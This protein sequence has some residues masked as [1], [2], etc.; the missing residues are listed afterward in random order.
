MDENF[1]TL[2]I[3]VEKAFLTLSR[4]FGLLLLD[5]HGGSSTS[6][7]PIPILRIKSVPLREIIDCLTEVLFIKVVQ[8][9]IAILALLFLGG[10]TDVLVAH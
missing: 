4:G 10:L 7:K 1:Q 6:I 9:G 5:L 2:D 8:K 3:M